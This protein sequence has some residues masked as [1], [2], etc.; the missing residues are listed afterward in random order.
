[1]ININS[2]DDLI[3][4]DSEQMYD[5]YWNYVEKLY[6]NFKYLLKSIK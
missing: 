1:M 4:V 2:I 6:I 5:K 3:I